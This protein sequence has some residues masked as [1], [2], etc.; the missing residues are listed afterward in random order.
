MPV[1]SLISPDIFADKFSGRIGLALFLGL[2]CGVT[3]ALATD[4]V[5]TLPGALSVDNKGA[6]NLTIPLMIPP[7]RG[8]MQPNLAL[9]YNSQ[10]GNGPIGVGW[11]LS[12]GFP[13]AITRGRSIFARDGY[14]HAGGNSD[15]AR[16]YLD[17]RR[18]IHANPAAPDSPY[19]Q[20]GN[21]Y[22][23]EVD[24]FVS[25]LATSTSSGTQR[26]HMDGFK[27][28]G[29][30]G[31]VTEFGNVDSNSADALDREG[32]SGAAQNPRGWKI[33]R[34]IDTIGN[35]STFFYNAYDDGAGHFTGEHVLAKIEYTSN[36]GA[37][38]D[39]EVRV[40]FLYSPDIPESTLRSDVFR[41]YNEG[42]SEM[43]RR[44]EAIEVDMHT[45]SGWVTMR[46][47]HLGFETSPGTTLSRLKH[48][49][50]DWRENAS[51]AWESLP[52][53]VL[54]YDDPT[55][56]TKPLA[57]PVNRATSPT[58][59]DARLTATG[60]FNG[61]GRT[62]RLIGGQ[63]YLSDGSS[64]LAPTEWINFAQTP[65]GWANSVK[66]GDLD[67][68]GKS[69]LVWTGG[70]PANTIY[71]ARST[72]SGFQPITGPSGSY[73]AVGP[74]QTWFDPTVAGNHP[75]AVASR[76]SLG[77]FNGDGRTDILLHTINGLFVAL[78]NGS[79]F[80]TLVWW[81]NTSG[82]DRFGYYWTGS[83]PTNPYQVE[84]L[85]VIEPIV[86]D[87]TGDGVD[88]YAWVS[89]ITIV[90]GNG[91]W[92]Y[93]STEFAV[94]V[95]Y[96][97][98]TGGFSGPETIHWQTNDGHNPSVTPADFILKVLP[99]DVNGDG[100]TDL[101]VLGKKDI[102]PG[103][104]EP[105]SWIL[106]L[107][108]WGSFER[109][110]DY[111]PM[112]DTFGTT[113]AP[114]HNVTY[115][116]D[117]QQNVDVTYIIDPYTGAFVFYE[118][119][120]SQRT[121]E[122]EQS[123]GMFLQD[124]NRDGRA[125]Y[126]MGLGSELGWWVKYGTLDGFL[127]AQPL[128]AHAQG[129]FTQTFGDY[130]PYTNQDGYGGVTLDTID[131]DGDGAPDWLLTSRYD[132]ANTYGPVL[133]QGR[134]PH[135]DRL[136]AVQDGLGATTQIAYSS[137][138]DPAIYTP[139]AAVSYPIRE[140]R[141]GQH[142]VSDVW[143][144]SGANGAPAQFSYQ[145]SGNRI[146]LSGRG[147]LGF[148]SFVTLDHQ[149]NLFKYQFLTQSF[150]MTGLTAREETYRHLGGG[151]FR[152]ISSHDNTVV[153]DEVVKSSTDSTRWGTVWPYISQAVE[154]R[155]EN[156]AT[157]HFTLSAPGP[158][159]QPEALFPQVKPTGEHIKIAAESWFD[160]ETATHTALPV[161]FNASDTTSGGA[162]AVT[163]VTSFGAITG[164]SLPGKIYFGNLAR[165]HTDFG[166][167]FAE[168][169][170][171]TY[172]APS[173]PLSGLV[174]TVATA[175]TSPGYGS[176]SAPTNSFTYW[177]KGTTPT[178][179]V[180]SETVNAGSAVYNL[181]TTYDRDT[182]GRVKDTV[183]S[184][185]D[186]STHA[187]HIGS[188]SV[189]SVAAFDSTFDLP[190]TG[191]NAAP[192]LHETTIDYHDLLGL[193]G[194]VTDV[195]GVQVTTDHD[196]LGRVKKV[197]N[198]STGIETVTEY[199]WTT[200]GATDWKK[201]QTVS[202]PDGPP[203]GLSLGSTYAVRTTTTVQP[204]VIAY[205]DRLGRVIRTV[206]EGFAGKTATT[207]TV[208]NV[209]GQVAAVSNPYATAPTD[210]TKY[211]Y[212]EL[213]RVKT[214]SAP[215]G[216]ITTSTYNGRFTSVSVDAA[217]LGGADPDAQATTTLVDAK[218]R[219]V[220]VWNADNPPTISGGATTTEASI[221]FK[222]DGF[223]RMRAT[224]LRGQTQEITATYDVL[225][226]QETLNDPDKGAW[227]YTN[228]VLGQVV[229]Q[230]DGNSAVTQ[231]KFD[232]LGRPLTRTTTQ[233][234]TGAPVESAN[235]FYYDTAT[236]AAASGSD[237][238]HLVA[239]GPKGWIG[240]LQRMTHALAAAPGYLDPGSAKYFYYDAKGRPQIVLS[241][242]DSKWFYTH[243]NYDGSN[244][245]DTVRHYWRP[246]PHESPSSYPGL[247]DSFGYTYGYDTESYVLTVTDTASRTWW[248][249]EATSGY[250]YL[251]RPVLVEKGSGHWTQRDYRASDG[252]LTAIKTGPS[253]GATT[254]QNLGFGFDGLGNLRTRTGKGGTETFGY[255]VLNRLTNSQQGA[256]SYFDNGNIK[257]KV[258]VGGETTADYVYGSS[259]PHAV[260]A[261]FGHAM[262]YDGNG[263]LLTRTPGAT[264]TWNLKWTGFDKPRWMAKTNSTGTAGSEFLY[265]ANRSRVVHLEFDAM[266]V[267]QP[268]H[269][270]RK[271]IYAA[272]AALEVDYTNTAATG[273]PVWQQ[274]KIR[275][276]I[277]APDGTAG[278]V[279]LPPA[280][281]GGMQRDLV[282]HHDHLGS[283]E[284]ITSFGNAV[285]SKFEADSGGK[286]GVFSED[287]W[288]ARRDPLDWTGVPT[289][290]DD[291]GPDSL[292]PRG[293]TGHE[294]LDGLGLIH[295]NGR[296][297]DPLL[298][299][300]LSADVLIQHPASL[301]SYNRYSY[302]LNNPLTLTDPS[303]WA[304]DSSD[305]GFMDA[306]VAYLKSVFIPDSHASPGNGEPTRDQ[307]D[308]AQ[309]RASAREGYEKGVKVLEAA[310]TVVNTANDLTGVNTALDIT[311]TVTG[312]DRLGLPAS[313][314]ESAERIVLA[315]SVGMVIKVGAKP[316]SEAASKLVGN[317]AKAIG[318]EGRAVVRAEEGAIKTGLKDEI[319]AAPAT[320]GGESAAA[321]DGR[322]AHENYGTALGDSYD[323]KVTLPSGK[324]PDAVNFDKKKV[325]ELKPDSERAVKRGEKQVEGYRK[326]LEK[327]T[328]D[329]WTS[330][331]DT[332]QRKKR[333]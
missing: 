211:S 67:G 301:Q 66:I 324:K 49:T 187:Q 121:S 285:A 326:E 271:K 45:A 11:A 116:Q 163:G 199:A 165:L 318:K 100:L 77:D 89:R 69:D 182:L 298:G 222:L 303:G 167:G 53:T 177:T 84:E 19:W 241:N 250:D 235:W 212:D 113:Q 193:P 325:R 174:D 209:L 106:Y 245:V 288:G 60:D 186:N 110:Y 95:S 20:V 262:T 129:Q 183:I 249:V 7:G 238:W 189:S 208:Y 315:A 221:E 154:Y 295:M 148:H 227:S 160:E 257:T 23:T 228:N 12:T 214:S 74:T 207:D 266:D 6:A 136:V 289:S 292:T 82:G 253:A 73:V 140:V 190:K 283:I 15:F 21:V 280:D 192:Y 194:S 254:I 180:E 51:A 62:D 231:S 152:Y 93:L 28:T 196:A 2:M 57:D 264:E 275:L 65:S 314:T 225:G 14:I 247:W 111:M 137:V 46:R 310:N 172:H 13:Q 321:A 286:G 258:G 320:R 158:S 122:K 54:T 42:Q 124:I 294:M 85:T 260:T 27:L 118:P 252:A 188:Y 81:G 97:T 39:P 330:A 316:L 218:G 101:L 119:V 109:I 156:S 44:L 206:R 191:K 307:G 185:Y 143:R 134:G 197:K 9:T 205:Y 139:G 8:G 162:N 277:P 274:E 123:G 75:D 48:I 272:G 34:V 138:A 78:A 278:A 80:N 229:N 96:A 79:G 173:G 164:L 273:A 30:D 114:T 87:F 204:A 213:G 220:K 117:S 4:L 88:D 18:L 333:N 234:G 322:R 202:H 317:V 112:A 261:A 128:W 166:G 200:A 63:V 230:T 233:A 293:F 198:I 71:A 169:V 290:T 308:Q 268:T 141:R 94:N 265:D 244:R 76:V 168:T 181:T 1:K 240:A 161:L 147:P 311:Q 259:R 309:Y 328:G 70:G 144:D 223:G 291:G 68:D 107:N 284:S 86:A 38:I 332:Y 3:A 276:Y 29:K 216:T 35:Q 5:G 31:T 329:D 59:F 135:W 263:N 210:W 195:N 50:S 153:F 224:K 25:I 145:Y 26:W 115:A 83:F 10:S 72:G 331:V 40:R 22:R 61:D 215:N 319:K 201:T 91:S 305:G 132:Q 236:N 41:G 219:T 246:S 108:T 32:S 146:D 90:D 269:Y 131:I 251:D 287:A 203:H 297:Y 56:N 296:I 24:S 270:T 226:R 176:E 323:T 127:P 313:R 178:P 120:F 58:G 125:D 327:V 37:S 102:A 105:T 279:E 33:K 306:A 159:S 184:G 64:F 248:A 98:R 171:T 255:D 281:L 126:I 300:F 55:P 133:C 170:T 157:E 17:G 256:I 237:A 267:T 242:I 92:S 43:R 103:G 312:V 150:P 99:G 36:P 149:T 16:L 52:A 243:T 151:K 130:S 175:V 302:V 179:L 304:D 104:D 217:N 282:Y 239:P 142:V 155:W 47:F 232:R 299:R